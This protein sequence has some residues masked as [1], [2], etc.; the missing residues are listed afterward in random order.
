MFRDPCGCGDI[1]NL[2]CDAWPAASII[3]NPPGVEASEVSLLQAEAKKGTSL[4]TLSELR[5]MRKNP[6]YHKAGSV[7]G[8]HVEVGDIV[9]LAFSDGTTKGTLYFDKVTI[10]RVGVVFGIW[11]FMVVVVVVVA[12]LVMTCI[13]LMDVIRFDGGGCNG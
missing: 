1:A 7:T 9:C 10:P 11:V 12:V 5:K 4:I 8:V 2:V 13:K 6:D 3:R